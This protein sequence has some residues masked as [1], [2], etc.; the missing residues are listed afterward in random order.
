MP[1]L[2]VSNTVPNVS[3]PGTNPASYS[4][5]GLVTT[6]FGNFNAIGFQTN[7]VGNGLL[8]NV[9]VIG[10]GKS[11]TAPG[12]AGTTGWVDTGNGA[13]SNPSTG[14]T[15]AQFFG[16]V[17][18]VGTVQVAVTIGGFN[19]NTRACLTALE[20]TG[21]GVNSSAF[22]TVDEFGKTNGNST[23]APGPTLTL[24]GAASPVLYLGASDNPNG[25]IS[26]GGTP[27]FVYGVDTTGGVA[28]CAGAVTAAATPNV[29]NIS[30]A[31]QWQV[32]ASEVFATIPTGSTGPVEIDLPAVPTGKMW[33]VSQVTFEFLPAVTATNL[34][35]TI[36][37]NGRVV[38]AGI[39]PVGGTGALGSFQ[40]PPNIAV[41]SG[42]TMTVQ[43][44]NVP[45]GISAIANFFYTELPANANP[46]QIGTVV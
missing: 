7:G 33:V 30:P 19:V 29:V 2:T 28:V 31:N 34:L 9:Y 41:R 17:T 20:V 27:G 23:T 43:M 12:G 4:T 40:G 14:D 11:I 44:T 25:S 21:P 32:L 39:N 18:Q 15:F 22:W 6:H 16:K 45:V 42:D 10:T 46:G 5:F 37:Q 36:L 24:S 26:A 35:A 1:I 38:K 3:G 8:L 13:V